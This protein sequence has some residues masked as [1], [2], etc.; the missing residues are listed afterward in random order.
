MIGLSA[1]PFAR[2][3]GRDVPGLGPLFEHLA[4]AT[5]IRELIDLGFLVDVDIYGPSEPDLSGVKIVAGDYHEAQLAPRGRPAAAHRRH[6]LAL[7][8]PGRGQA[9]GLLRHLDRALASTSWSSSTRPACRP[10][11]S[12]ATPRRER[13]AVLERFER[14]ETRVICNVGVLAEGWDC[15]VCEV[16]ILARPTRSLTRYIQMAGRILRPHEGKAR[17][18]ILDHSGTVRRLGFPTDDLPL[19][20]DDGTP[21]RRA[22]ARAEGAVAGALPVLPLPDPRESAGLPGLRLH[23][24]AAGERSSRETENSFNFA[25]ERSP[26]PTRSRS[27]AS[28]SATRASRGYKPGWAA[29]KTREL[30]GTW[31]A[32]KEGITPATPSPDTMRLIRYLNIRHAKSREAHAA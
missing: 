9:D 8:P 13:R 21:R 17:G 26:P 18:L 32:R 12:T 22:S 6:R 4:V 25:G 10:S 30:F 24:E 16:M 2:G 23:A 20:L 29:H 19:E 7:A 28:S 11:T 1:T 14:G 15:P 31:P 3:L 5:T 27:T